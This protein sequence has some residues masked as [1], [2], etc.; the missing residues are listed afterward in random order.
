MPGQNCKGMAVKYYSEFSQLDS[1]TNTTAVIRVELSNDDYTGSPVELIGGADPLRID[2]AH[3]EKMQPIRGSRAVLQY[4]VNSGQF[5]AQE[6]YTDDEQYWK[7]D[8]FRDGQVIWRGFVIPDGC[9][10]PFMD[11][12]YTVT[13]Q[14]VDGLALLKNYDYTNMGQSTVVKTISNCLAP[15]STNLNINTYTLLEYDGQ[16]V[17]SD[18][19][20]EV[21]IYGEQFSGAG[22]REPMNRYDALRSVL[23]SWGAI[24][25]QRHGEWVV[26]RVVDVLAQSSYSFFRYNYLGQY[27]DRNEINLS[28][29]LGNTNETD[30]RHVNADQLRRNDFPYKEVKVRYNYGFLTNILSYPAQRF[31]RGL[32]NGEFQFW[33]KENG[34]NAVPREY[35]SDPYAVIY[36]KDTNGPHLMLM[37]SERPTVGP[38]QSFKF[39]ISFNVSEADGLPVGIAFIDSGDNWYYLGPD[40]FS[41]TYNY[42]YFLNHRGVEGPGSGDYSIGLGEDTTGVWEF[43]TRSDLGTGELAIIIYPAYFFSGN[44]SNESGEARLYNVRL[45]PV[46]GGRATIGQRATVTNAGNY[47]TKPDEI[48]IYHGESNFSGYVGTMFKAD[49]SPTDG[50]YRGPATGKQPFI[51]IMAEDIMYMHG[52]PMTIYTGSVYGYFDYLSIIKITNGLDGKF[53]PV[54]AEYDVKNNTT[55]VELIEVSNTPIN[56]SRNKVEE[57]PADSVDVNVSDA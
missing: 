54:S 39:E 55:Q 5:T 3:T 57:I 22:E 12:P 24:I 36:G 7:V 6:L 19:F 18:T 17:G 8:I 14:A 46:P 45:T 34:I 4:I 16:A 20:N 10:E 13:I 50:F 52:R 41:L 25:Q 30:I 11:A 33:S 51:Q 47:T 9:S 48:E 28:L 49:D 42:R 53:L 43:T 21:K 27:I 26:C 37:P 35:D 44:I 56:L 15:I 29:T 1:R 32:I 31:H 2:Y 23:S 38:D 40:G